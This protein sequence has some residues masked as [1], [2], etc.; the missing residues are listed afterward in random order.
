MNILFRAT[1][2]IKRLQ[3]ALI[4]YYPSEKITACPNNKNMYYPIL[5]DY[6]YQLRMYYNQQKCYN[7]SHLISNSSNNIFP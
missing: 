1:P 2:V 4:A 5:D 6:Q 3:P 7:L